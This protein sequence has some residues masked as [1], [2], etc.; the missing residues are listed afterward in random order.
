MDNISTT[1]NLSDPPKNSIFNKDQVDVV[2]YHGYCSDGFG[3]AF[4]I[5]YYFKTR[6][7]LEVA[8]KIM[9]IP[10]Y[11]Q[12]DLQNFSLEFLDKIRNKN[13]IMCDFSYKYHLL[14]E[15]INVSNTFIVLDHHKTAQI[16]LSKIPNDLKIFCLEKS[17]VG[18]TWEYFF[19]DKPIPKFLAHIQD[20]DIWTYKVPQTSEFI[21]YFYEQEFDFNLWETFL[22]EQIVDKAID[23]GSK[24]LEYQKIIM[25][26]IIKR[27]SYVIQNVNNKLSIVLYCNSPEF[28]SDLGN[29]LLY[30]FPFGDFS[31]VW[32]YS[33]YKDESYY[34]L[35][36]TNDRYD[37]SVIA[38]QFGGG[39]HRNAS[40]LAFSGIKGCLP[41]EKV[42]DCGLLELFSQ[43]TKGTIDLGEKHSC[44]LFKTKEI[45]SEWFEQKYT[46]LIRRKYTNYIYLAF[47]ISDTDKNYTVFQNDKFS[48]DNITKYTLDEF[49]KIFQPLNSINSTIV[50]LCI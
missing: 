49:S 19:P 9:Y 43:S 31:C 32:D 10:C 24:W 5:W 25:S 15:I 18:I 2:L 41:F 35:R 48:L 14:M 27:T 22:E 7:G 33:L 45:R 8:D 16:E 29:R 11:H 44:I 34:S 28:K 26:K 30:H 1:V 21:T 13:V 40:G 37:V 50:E 4:I 36:S 23:C 38:T 42:D 12:K 17:G 6:Y 3:S 20:R 46:D 47:E 39:G